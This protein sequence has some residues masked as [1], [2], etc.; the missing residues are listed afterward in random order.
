MVRNREVKSEQSND[1]AD[2]SLGLPQ[3][4]AKHHAHRQGCADR[5]GRVMRLAAWRGS[6]LRP[7]RLDR[8]V[9]KPHGQAAPLPQRSVILRPVGDPISGLGDPMAMLSMV[10]ERQGEGSGEANGPPDMWSRPFARNWDRVRATTWPSPFQ[11]SFTATRQAV[12]REA[13]SGMALK[14]IRTE[15]DPLRGSNLLAETHLLSSWQ[16]R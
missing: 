6:R 2:Q 3:C 11:S 7:P 14:A 5:Q 12:G 15:T 8:L 10:F 9:G 13:N 4:Q 1:G 16:I